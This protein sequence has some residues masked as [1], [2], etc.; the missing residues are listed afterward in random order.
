M[1]NIAHMTGRIRDE[2]LGRYGVTLM[3]SSVLYMVKALGENATPKNLS[4][5]L[6]REPPTISDGLARMEKLG[7]I[8]KVPLNRRGQIRILLTKAGEQAYS[9]ST[10]RA[11]IQ[12]IMARVPPE[13]CRE[14]K[15]L[16]QEMRQA[17]MEYMEL[18]PQDTILPAV[19]GARKS[20]RAG[21]SAVEKERKSG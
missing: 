20:K 16:L 18:A 2:E 10:L 17:V 11:S 6:F 9:D 21:A 3:Q 13:K 7:L 14:L 5:W 15:L 1:R 19:P 4:K 12:K 8:K